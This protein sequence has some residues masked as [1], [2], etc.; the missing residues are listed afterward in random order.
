M[1]RSNE[2]WGFKNR[3]KVSNYPRKRKQN[4]YKVAQY[5]ECSISLLKIYNKRKRF[6]FL[7][8][9]FYFM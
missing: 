8:Q 2:N 5:T 1:L 4:L 6:T 9:E 7:T 3:T